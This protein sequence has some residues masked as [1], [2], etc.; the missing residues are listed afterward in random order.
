MTRI[1]GA[2]LAG[3]M[4]L[5]MLGVGPVP[6]ADAQGRRGQDVP[7]WLETAP[8]TRAST[9]HLDVRAL[10]PAAARDGVVSLQLRVTPRAGMR[11]YAPDVTGYVPLSLTLDVSA[12]VNVKAPD[13]PA[14]VDYVF[15][16]TGERSRVYDEAFT[17]TQR[18]RLPRGSAGLANVTAT[19][20]Y[21][22]CD[23]TLCY[24]PASVRV[25]WTD[26]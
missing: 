11:V 22:A 2:W 10:P 4:S 21:Q 17:V 9:A 25:R 1:A 12:D 5:V 3:A 13:Y 19:L 24:K 26:D 7:G 23:D 16:P 8:T 18:V 14:P 20:R 15:P 6:A